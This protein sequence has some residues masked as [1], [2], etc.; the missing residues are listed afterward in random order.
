MG[1]VLDGQGLIPARGKRGIFLFS[2]VSRLAL[3][4]IQS[5]IQWVL[6]A[7]SLEVKWPVREADHSLLSSAK[8]M[9][10]GAIPPFLQISSWRSA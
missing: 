1:N 9:N 6:G 2:A 7:V 8:V 3:G 5:P 4:S 10:G